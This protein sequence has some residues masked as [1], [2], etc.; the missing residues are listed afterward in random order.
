MEMLM[1][2]KKNAANCPHYMA[3]RRQNAAYPSTG[4]AECSSNLH[5]LLDRLLGA[6][7]NIL[8]NFYWNYMVIVSVQ[9]VTIEFSVNV[10][11]LKFVIGQLDKVLIL[12]DITV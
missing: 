4:P 9:M 7:L 8:A 11:F 3:Y 2:R 6:V 10:L 5:S 12:S 1:Q